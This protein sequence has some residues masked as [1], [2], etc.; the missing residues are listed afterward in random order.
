M[1]N[2]I[3][4]YLLFLLQGV[5]LEPPACLLAAGLTGL[6]QTFLLYIALDVTANSIWEI[7]CFVL[8]GFDLNTVHKL[9]SKEKKSR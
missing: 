5:S 8:D 9:S 6:N 2:N 7:D 1:L 4:R 3:L